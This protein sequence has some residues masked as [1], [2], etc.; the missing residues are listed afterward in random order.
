MATH[1][2]RICRMLVVLLA[3]IAMAWPNTA[4]R[5]D[6][7]LIGTNWRVAEIDGKPVIGAGTLIFRQGSAGGRASCNSFGSTFEANGTAVSF[8]QIISTKMY[9]NGRMELEQAL[10]RALEA[11]VKTERH[12]EALVLADAGDKPRVKLVK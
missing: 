3:L 5:A 6:S 7:G 8:R 4:P 9:C 2:D 12:S 11:S 10:F 1:A